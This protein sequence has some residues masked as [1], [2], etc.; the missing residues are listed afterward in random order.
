MVP[1]ESKEVE[2][3]G[4]FYTLTRCL[5]NHYTAWKDGAPYPYKVFIGR[6]VPVKCE[7]AD[8]IWRG[9]SRPCKHIAMVRRL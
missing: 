8:F 1:G 6:G 5:D 7:C 3:E 4:E 9:R 2:W